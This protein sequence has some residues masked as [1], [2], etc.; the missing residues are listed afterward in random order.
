MYIIT[1]WLHS[2]VVLVH[3]N[4]LIYLT[5]LVHIGTFQVDPWSTYSGLDHAQATVEVDLRF[6]YISFTISNHPFDCGELDL[7]TSSLQER[8]LLTRQTVV[9]LLLRGSSMLLGDLHGVLVCHMSFL[10]HCGLLSG[11]VLMS[12]CMRYTNTHHYW[13]GNQSLIALGSLAGIHL[14]GILT[15]CTEFML[16]LWLVLVVWRTLVPH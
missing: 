4:T 2:S 14:R 10:A 6:H 16:T 3:L 1:S 8:L 12:H 13:Y 5:L 9:N 7:P 15:W 11:V